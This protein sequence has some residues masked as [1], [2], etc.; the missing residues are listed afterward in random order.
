MTGVSAAS[1]WRRCFQHGPPEWIMRRVTESGSRS[2]EP[3]ALHR[4]DS[5]RLG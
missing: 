5:L 2:P 1:T 3:T 4:L